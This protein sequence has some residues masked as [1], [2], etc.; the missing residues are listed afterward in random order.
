M[1][2]MII[3]R[4][5]PA[6]A[7]ELRVLLSG[8]FVEDSVCLLSFKWR[9]RLRKEDVV[10]GAIAGWLQA[11]DYHT[12]GWAHEAAAIA[13]GACRTSGPIDIAGSAETE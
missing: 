13:A 5:M 9:G 1:A 4:A 8:V 6:F 3:P 12:D 10:R 11:E 7:P 2:G